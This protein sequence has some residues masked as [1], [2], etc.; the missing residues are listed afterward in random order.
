MKKKLKPTPQLQEKNNSKGSGFLIKK[1]EGE[2]EGKSY[3]SSFKRKDLLTQNFIS[4][5]SNVKNER[6]KARYSQINKKK[7]VASRPTLK[8]WLQKLL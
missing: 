2:N 4:S 5:K 7:L 1:H 3:F 6:G 8:E